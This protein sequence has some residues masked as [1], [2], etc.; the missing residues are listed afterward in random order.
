MLKVQHVRIFAQINDNSTKVI[1]RMQRNN[2][3][4]AMPNTSHRC[5]EEI[6]PEQASLRLE[7]PMLTL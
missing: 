4:D 3:F 7:N 1:F 2:T 5:V 6:P